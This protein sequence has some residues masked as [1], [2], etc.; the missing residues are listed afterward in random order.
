[1]TLPGRIAP[2]RGQTSSSGLVALTLLF[3]LSLPAVT[4]RLYASDEIEYFSY[5]RSLW[6]DRDLSFDNEYRY[7]YDRGIARAYGFHETFLERTSETGLR[8]NFG[9]IGSAILWA[10]MYAVADLGVRIARAGGS[11]VAADG[12][13]R[14]YIA[15]VAYGSA[16][17]GFLAL[18]ISA[19]V[20]RKLTGSGP[21]ASALVWIGTPLPFYMYLAPGMAHACSS[22]AV[23]AFVIVWLRVRQQWSTRGLAALGALGA[24]M[25]MVREQDAFFVTG[26][27]AD[28]AWTLA[29]DLRAGRSSLAIR[30]LGAAAAGAAVFL[31]CMTPQLWAYQVLNG[32]FGPSR[33]VSDKMRWQAPHAIQVLF[34]PEHGFF[35]WTPLALLSIAGLLLWAFRDRGDAVPDASVRRISVCLIVMFAAQVYITGSV[36]T[37]TVAGSFGQ[38]RFVGTTVILVAGLATLMRLARAWQRGSLGAIVAL[39]V[40]W[41]LG[42]MAQF[43]AGL[44]D[45]Q[46]LE[47]ARNA[48][49]T[50]VVIPRSAPSLA[51]RYLF[52]RSSFYRT[53]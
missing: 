51:Y 15:A 17:Y 39:S 31:L 32:R 4:L 44:M 42:L 20:A 22:F 11:H 7:F 12:F 49:N 27:I 24:L 36:G 41:N 30:R 9:T 47:P 23:A 16:L 38:R 43:G 14:P 8:L 18:V 28:F 40:W 50:F 1:M 34:S 3:V 53:P 48:Y 37:W 33:V 2:R 35:V 13:S 21:V 46:R 5:L 19:Q 26:V 10:P 6:F 45:R 52:H 25:T 29:D